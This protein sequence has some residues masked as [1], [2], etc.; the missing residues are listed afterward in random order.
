MSFLFPLYALGAL[1]ILGPLI[2]H[3]TRSRPKTEVPFSATLFLSPSAI[4]SKEKKKFEHW[5]LAAV[6][7]LLLVV[8]AIA[9]M[10]PFQP[11]E[12]EV[13]A[14]I[15][16]SRATWILVDSSASMQREGYWIAA[17]DL[18]REWIES[19]K[20]T[21]DRVLWWFDSSPQTGLDRGG[22]ISNAMD[23][24]MW[25][26]EA[27][28]VL[29]S[30]TP[31]WQSTDLGLAIELALE[32]V[33]SFLDTHGGVDG[34][35]S[36]AV[37]SE[38]RSAEIVVISDFQSGTSLESL[39]GLNWPKNVQVIPEVVQGSD[40]FGVSLQSA[41]AFERVESDETTGLSAD[42]S[43]QNAENK[44][45]LVQIWR[46]SLRLENVE[47]SDVN[48]VRLDWKSAGG[49]SEDQVR[50]FEVTSG[51]E[52]PVD[53]P[54]QSGNTTTVAIRLES[55]NTN[56]IF[57]SFSIEANAPNDPEL[58][59]SL[60]LSLAAPAPTPVRWVS[61]SAEDS[62]SD[63]ASE[64]K[65]FIEQV[66]GSLS[67]EVDF[68]SLLWSE[69]ASGDPN[70]EPLLTSP[71]KVFW[72]LDGAPE[73]G[74]FSLPIWKI[75]SAGLKSGGAV[76]LILNEAQD[77]MALAGL[78]DASMADIASESESSAKGYT[79]TELD[80]KHPWLAPFRDP[81]V[82]D[83]SKIR[84]FE[85][86]ALDISSTGLESTT[87]A[88]FGPNRPA[89]LDVTV[90]NGM[91]SVWT[92]GFGFKQSQFA[93]TTKFVAFWNAILR[94]GFAYREPPTQKTVGD[95]LS[96]V[97]LKDALQLQ[98]D[99][100]LLDLDGQ[101]LESDV[102]KPARPGVYAVQSKNSGNVIGAFALNLDRSEMFYDPMDLSN[103]LKYNVPLSLSGS[104][105]KNSATSRQMSESDSAATEPAQNSNRLN[106][107]NS[108]ASANLA[109]SMQLENQQK[110]WKYFL[111]VALCLGL[112]ETAL[113]GYWTSNSKSTQQSSTTKA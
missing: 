67:G 107:S 108:A 63:S 36:D 75:L 18:A 95:T 86:Q 64:R 2:W 49:E 24:T 23:P 12:S 35:G 41:T 50:A 1:A 77:A 26:S 9:F 57:G 54:I 38:V 81:S 76:S 105:S 14:G 112:I 89:W 13:G 92:S 87:V 44:D 110:W 93:R 8:L 90:G 19:S 65:F 47:E 20:E 28:R 111:L 52:L 37:Q 5:L 34:S 85:R 61:S 42:S 11:A 7:M 83:F 78:T 59:N 17:Q 25:K 80:F 4:T 113:A 103:L 94:S 6:R 104:I 109:R 102:L 73:S 66:F 53:W 15:E 30:K 99:L 100:T 97:D 27:L 39:N 70:S 60:Y 68:K 46:G 74:D 22:S 98:D 79:L 84:F 43:A 71:E 88:A 62:K 101:A 51:Q 56:P 33:E 55:K 3:F 32:D 69:I 96:L 58:D 31:S 45:S 82:S 91:L 16:G 10:R 72:I 40:Q 29:D 48:Q 106:L 21:G